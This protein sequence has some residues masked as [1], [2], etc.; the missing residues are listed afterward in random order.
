VQVVFPV[1]SGPD[2]NQGALVIQDPLEATGHSCLPPSLPASGSLCLLPES[3]CFLDRLSFSA[4]PLDS[5]ELSEALDP[6]MS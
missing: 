6:R 4:L 1:D 5:P 3:C 2:R